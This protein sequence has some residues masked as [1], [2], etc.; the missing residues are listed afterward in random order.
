M[1]ATLQ[2]ADPPRTD[3]GSLGQRLLGQPSGDPEAP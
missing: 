1:G 3:A 2:I